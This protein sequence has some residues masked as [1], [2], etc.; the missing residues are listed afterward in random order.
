M[1]KIAYAFLYVFLLLTIVVVPICGNAQGTI[2]I[3][4]KTQRFLD[5][6]SDFDRSKHLNIH[7]NFSNTSDPDL[8]S[9]RNTYNIASTYVGSRRFWSPLNFVDDDAAG[10][11]P[12]VS[13]TYNGTRAVNGR[14]ATGVAKSLMHNASTDYSVTDISTRSLNV[15][16]YIARSFKDE[17]SSVP[18]FYEPF[19]EPMVHASD[20]YPA[21]SSGAKNDIIITKICEFYRDMGQAMHALPELQNM[22]IIGFASAWP[23]MEFNDF[24]IWNARQKKFMD[25]A[26]ADMDGFSIHLY[27]GSGLNNTGGRRSGSNIEAVMDMIEAYSS[28]S[29]GEVKP[30]AITEYGRLVQSQPGWTSGGTVSNYEAVENSQA[31]RSQIHMVMSFMERGDDMLLSIPFS[32]GKSDPYVDLFSR[33][34]LWVLQP[35]GSYKLTE[36][37][38][39][40]EIWKDVQGKRIR[41]ESTNID[42]QTQAFVDGNKLYVVLNNLNDATQNV[43]LNLV[44]ATGLQSVHTKRL[45]IFTSAVPQLT[46]S[47]SSSAPASIS[48]AY[49]ETAVLTYTFSSN[50]SF[51]NDI[52]SKKYYATETLKPISANT[53]VTFTINGVNKGSGS[54][55]ATL[56]LGVGRNQGADLTP[57]I[58]IN[59]QAVSYN[60]DIIRGYDQNNR[61]R[62][63]GTLEIP[64]DL[65]LLNSGTNT[66]KVKFTDNG[67]HV[68]STI[69]QVQ[70]YANPVNL[71]AGPI[72]TFQNVG[73]NKYMGTSNPNAMATVSTAGTTEEF[74]IID[75][76]GG[77]LAGG[78]VALKGSNGLYVS[79]E[80]GTQAMTCL[81]STIG[82]W[83][84][85]TFLDYGGGAYVFQGNNNLYLRE[86]MICT[87]PTVSTWQQWNMNVI[88]AP[89]NLASFQNV[90][91]NKY[92]GT[93][94]PNKMATVSSVG[95]TE[96]FEIID[97]GGGQVALKGS[98]GLYVSSEDG[99]KEMTCSRTTIGAWEKFT[100]EDQGDGTHAI[101]G[102]TGQYLR[103]NMIC[104]SSTISSWQ[105]WT[106]TTGLS[107]R[108]AKPQTQA[109]GLE[110]YPNPVSGGPLLIKWEAA[111]AP[112]SIKIMDLQGAL[113][114]EAK[115]VNG[116]YKI[117]Q[118]TL[119]TMGVYI[120]TVDDGT[121]VAYSK[122]V[123]KGN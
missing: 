101:K 2:T 59:N 23:E 50:V 105:K 97:V 62:F 1:K 117:P 79:S 9:F 14:V 123:V 102:S 40:Y 100:L 20:F 4:H 38:Y 89:A 98:N 24:S 96:K 17:W 112:F 85:F 15:A 10:T 7:T 37:K 77:N 121:Q 28:T 53:D 25:I 66:V 34:A 113:I 30:L 84:Q 99:L 32:V 29:Y 58:T 78:L 69:L 46:T 110:V 108:K 81:R 116:T 44:D 70:T 19:N 26:G 21:P 48:L 114:F 119:A 68:S 42:V 115:N 82:A 35:D 122:V 12:G 63:F 49:G 3:D 52:T 47:T 95:S 60:G 55:Y 103:E 71:P 111:Q 57:T 18:T 56:R 106:I 73:S 92:I 75:L 6:V 67:G 39:F 86:N 93:S 72:V 8:V 91:S 31:V 109:A 107:P 118:T 41:F 88:S 80:N 27:D 87:S 61:T 16:D 83:E 54:G 120:L 22:K 33:A 104:T 45:K 5:G 74:E 64:V 90:G 76:D 11:I 51:T 94:D 36:R 43:N 65:S 13:N